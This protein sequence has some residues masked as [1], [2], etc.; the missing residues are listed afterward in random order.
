MYRKVSEIRITKE[1][2]E[3]LPEATSSIG[4]MLNRFF[5]KEEVNENVTSVVIEAMLKAGVTLGPDLQFVGYNISKDIVF[6][7]ENGKV[8]YRFE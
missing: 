1:L 7:V 2:L 4:S 6:I 3:E 8:T 5:V